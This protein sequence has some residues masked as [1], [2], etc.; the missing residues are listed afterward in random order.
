MT[1]KISPGGMG[2]I[3]NYPVARMGYGAMSLG[4]GLPESHAIALLRR[5]V[6]L[7]LNHIDTASFY[8]AGEINRRIRRALAPYPEDLVIVSKVGYRPAPGLSPSHRRSSPPNCG[9][10]SI[11][12]SASLDSSRFRR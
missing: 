10:P 2:A 8:E 1:V 6:D 4:Q 12:T 9:R 3:G 7:G 11:W 5:A